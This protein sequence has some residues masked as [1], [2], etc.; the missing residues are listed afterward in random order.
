MDAALLQDPRR[1]DVILS[2]EE[3]ETPMS[4]LEFGSSSRPVDII[5]SHANGFNAQTYRMILAPLAGTLRI[6]APDLR[7][8]GATRLAYRSEGRLNWNDLVTDLVRLV[9]QFEGPPVI[10][11]GHSLGACIS[12]F[13]AAQ[14]PHRVRK[15]VLFEPVI[16]PFWAGGLTLFPHLAH[17]L[18][19]KTPIYRGAIKR[20]RQ[21]ASVEEA[22]T[23]YRGR[24]AFTGWPDMILADYLGGGL[25]MTETGA[26]ELACDPQWD[27]SNYA[28]HA[29]NTWGALMSLKIPIEI[30]K[31][32][33]GS[34]THLTP[35]A[36]HLGIRS[37]S[38]TEIPDTTHFLPMLRPDVVRDA[39]LGPAV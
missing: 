7:G 10:L 19:K 24:G 30:Y 35:F 6:I 13:A 34:L 17:Y 3:A 12:I 27:A 39:L 14:L 37:L 20:R 23:T 16:W 4:V 18:A 29:N 26:V 36:R 33:E 25:R 5:F 1:K 8:H 31:G 32:G 15:L 21:F 11:S 9:S 28:A 38:L 22:M 2:L